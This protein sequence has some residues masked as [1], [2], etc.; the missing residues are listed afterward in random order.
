MNTNYL[1]ETVLSILIFDH[2]IWSNKWSFY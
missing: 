1:W 2:T